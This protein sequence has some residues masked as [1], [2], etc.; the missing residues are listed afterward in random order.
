VASVAPAARSSPQPEMARCRTTAAEGQ[1]LSVRGDQPMAPRRRLRRGRRRRQ[2]RRPRRNVAG[3]S[4]KSAF[5]C[6]AN[7]SSNA[8]LSLVPQGNEPAPV[9]ETRTRVA[10]TRSR[11]PPAPAEQRD[12]WFRSP[13]SETRPTPSLLSGAAEQVPC[14]M[15]S[16]SPVIKRADLGDKGVYYRRHGGSVQFV[17]RSVTVLRQP[18]D[19]WRSVRRPKELTAVP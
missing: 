14:V 3:C 16:R 12:T 11:Q 10:A 6:H 1:D 19:G 13:R 5:D 15:G 18:E 4:A 8:P 9:A 17:R 2:S 7:A